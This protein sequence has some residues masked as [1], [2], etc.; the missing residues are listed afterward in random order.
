MKNKKQP[1][2]DVPLFMKIRISLSLV[3]TLGMAYIALA[4]E[5]GGE[6]WK[7]LPDP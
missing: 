1:G 7:L 5:E 2:M 3:L 4:C 6:R